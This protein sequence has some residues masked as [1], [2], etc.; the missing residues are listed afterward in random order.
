MDIFFSCS[1]C[2]S[3][4]TSN[5]RCRLYTVTM[6][7]FLQLQ[8]NNCLTLCLLLRLGEYWFRISHYVYHCNRPLTPVLRQNR[9][10]LMY[11]VYTYLIYLHRFTY[12]YISEVGIAN[13]FL[14]PLIANPLIFLSPLNA[15]PLIC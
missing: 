8:C 6:T 1:Q 4:T 10:S 11:D 14:S 7:T 3:P 13:F 2:F 12:A 9:C 5:I 15:N